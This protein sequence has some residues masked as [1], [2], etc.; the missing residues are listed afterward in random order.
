MTLGGLLS[1]AHYADMSMSQREFGGR[2]RVTPPCG[3]DLAYSDFGPPAFVTWDVIA[4]RKAAALERLSE[5]GATAEHRDDPW[6]ANLCWRKR[7]E[8]HAEATAIK[9]GVRNH[10]ALMKFTRERIW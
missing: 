6:L 7:A 3:T 10:A 1:R 4:R 5:Q 9:Q 8:L 2:T